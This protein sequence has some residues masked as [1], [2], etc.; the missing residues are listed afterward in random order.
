MELINLLE[1]QV[2]ILVAVRLAHDEI[3]SFRKTS[4]PISPSSGHCRRLLLLTNIYYRVR[5]HMM[6]A[7]YGDAGTTQSRH[8]RITECAVFVS[9]IIV[10][11]ADRGSPPHAPPNR[12][13]ERGDTDT[14]DV[15]MAGEA[16][17]S[18]RQRCVETKNGTQ[19]S[20]GGTA[21]GK[22]ERDGKRGERRRVGRAGRETE[23]KTVATGDKENGATGEKRIPGKLRK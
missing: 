3:P 12:H 14:G 18:S 11:S 20:R 15:R 2:E 19:A 4:E 10:V 13:G 8:K 6:C 16:E 9:S 22:I 23:R 21:G 17:G 5:V 7:E 1:G